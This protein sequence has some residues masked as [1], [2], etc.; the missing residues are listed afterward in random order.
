[1]SEICFLHMPF[2][3][4]GHP[5]MALSVLAA[6]CR[7]AGIETSVLYGTLRLAQQVSLKE[8]MRLLGSSHRFTFL[9]EILF[10]P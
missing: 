6:E 2:A 3:M 7:A 8:Y 4:P 5:S 10:K 1:M 9:G